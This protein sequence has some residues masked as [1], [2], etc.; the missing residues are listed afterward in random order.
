MR[1]FP[2]LDDAL[3]AFLQQ[4]VAINIGTRNARLAPSACYVG[5]ALV[6]PDRKHLTVFVPEVGAGR[7]LADLQANG[8]A[9]VVFARPEDDRACQ[10]KGTFVSARPATDAESPIVHEQYAGF[11]RQ[12]EII[13]M[14]GESTRSWI[15]WP[16]V[17]VRLRVTAVF[18]Q[19]P[20][21]KAGA[22]IA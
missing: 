10:V 16:A 11:L 13:G 14:P 18:D 8:Q 9:A 4:G 19:T 12:L 3:T 5:A 7:V 15:V 21:P 20:G 2:M 17:A 1:L 22:V 6:D